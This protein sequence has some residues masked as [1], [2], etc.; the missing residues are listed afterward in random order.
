MSATSVIVEQVLFSG[1]FLALVTIIHEIT[2]RVKVPFT[3]ALLVMGMVVKYYLAQSGG[4]LPVELTPD[5]IYFVLL[6]LLLFGAAMHIN[7]HQFRL[8]FKTISFLSTFGLLLGVSVVGVGVSVFAGLPIMD[9]LLFGALISATDPIAVLSIFKQLGAPRRLALIAD[10]ESMFNDATAV[11]VFRI[12]AG[13]VLVGEQVSPSLV[14]GGIG[15]LIYVFFGSIVVGAVLG[16]LISQLIAWIQDDPLVETTLTLVAALMAFVAMEH[17]LHLSGVISSVVAGLVMGNWGRARFSASVIEFVRTFW[18]YLGFLAVAIVFFFSTVEMDLGQ[19]VHTPLR[20]LIVVAVVLVARAISVYS[21]FWVT[22]RNR[23]FADEP[24]VP[25]SWQ[26]IMN[27][28]GLRG[29]IPLV[30]VFSLPEDYIYREDILGFTLAT[31]LF[32]LFVNGLTIE[33]LL[34]RMKLHHPK[35]EEAI[36]K[37]EEDIIRAEEAREKLNVL[38]QNEFTERLRKMVDKRIQEEIKEH[39]EVLRSHISESGQVEKSLRLQTVLLQRAI[40]QRLFREGQISEDV[41]F[42]FETQ[43]DLRADELEYPEKFVG[44]KTKSKKLSGEEMH[45]HRVS[46]LKEREM[47]SSGWIRRYVRASWEELVL[48]RYSMLRVRAMTAQEVVEYLDR[49]EK[50]LGSVL[51]SS[52][53]V[54]RAEYLGYVRENRADKLKLEKKYPTLT[55]S[56]RAQ[57]LE[58]LIAPNTENIG[59]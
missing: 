47:R 24:D 59:H 4:H 3:V 52:V 51:T 46:Q 45:N 14:L 7:L 41:L 30:L 26:H 12:L 49:V 18:D 35:A 15:E 31:F 20:Y 2:K 55:E 19:F 42:E 16:Y 48:E 40:V 9:A 37:E 17:Y 8:Q 57:L 13:V 34:K 58:R 33:W 27:W 36:I 6:P 21:T 25:M 38:P 32:T 43:L 22:N 10:G 23:L 1:A 29:V 53:A 54:V 56:F 50:T 11:I 44:K 5:F 28:G 39:E